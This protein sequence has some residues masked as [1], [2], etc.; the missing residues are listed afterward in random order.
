LTVPA[1]FSEIQK[2]GCRGREEGGYVPFCIL[3]LGQR[4]E[5]PS[6]SLYIVQHIKLPYPGMSFSESQQYTGSLPNKKCSEKEIEG[7][8][9]AA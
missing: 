9:W 1:F 6:L 2:W 5:F 7:A 4:R 3:V 8:G